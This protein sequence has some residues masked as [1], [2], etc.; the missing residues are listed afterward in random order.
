MKSRHF[1]N[2]YEIRTYMKILITL[3]YQHLALYILSS[4]VISIPLHGLS[5]LT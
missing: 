3:A 2:N 4:E 5:V 1:I